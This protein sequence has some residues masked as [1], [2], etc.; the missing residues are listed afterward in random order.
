MV[1]VGGVVDFFFVSLGSGWDGLMM[2]GWAGILAFF[3][4]CGGWDIRGDVFGFLGLYGLRG[5]FV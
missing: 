1:F 5:S 3:F 4:F 2:M